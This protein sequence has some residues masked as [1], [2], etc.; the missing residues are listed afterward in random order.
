LGDT[1]NIAARLEGETRNAGF[2]V[3]ISEA[4]VEAARK[5]STDDIAGMLLEAQ[6]VLL[7]RIRLKGV[8]NGINAYAIGKLAAN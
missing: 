1:V 2:R 7:E 8:P 6:A 3:L 5:Q 4:T